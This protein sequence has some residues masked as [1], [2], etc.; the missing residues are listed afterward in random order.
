MLEGIDVGGCFTK[1]SL[2]HYQTFPYPLF[3]YNYTFLAIIL[4]VLPI[5][6]ITSCVRMLFIYLRTRTRQQNVTKK[7]D[8]QKTKYKIQNR[9]N[10][11]QGG[12]KREEEHT[13]EIWN[14]RNTMQ[15]SRLLSHTFYYC[16]QTV[17]YFFYCLLSLHDRLY[18]PHTHTLNF[19]DGSTY[20]LINNTHHH[21]LLATTH[22]HCPP[23][24]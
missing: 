7:Q 21:C 8:T 13:R 24:Y 3:L 16:S 12:G 11:N 2:I 17:Y 14:G 20:T 6:H 1:P 5:F 19:G 4:S 22:L 23:H 15:F 10:L 9:G 18:P